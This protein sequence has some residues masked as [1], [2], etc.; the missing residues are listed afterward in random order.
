[1][2]KARFP[3]GFEFEIT[4]EMAEKIRRIQRAIRSTNEKIN[5]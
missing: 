2:K 3:N 5:P 4:D 1:M